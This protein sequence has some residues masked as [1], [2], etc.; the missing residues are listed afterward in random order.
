[1]LG[2]SL[3]NDLTSSVPCCGKP[4]PRLVFPV[5]VPFTTLVSYWFG[6]DPSQQ[7]GNGPVSCVVGAGITVGLKIFK[8]ML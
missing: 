2:S 8:L 3:M 6:E 1:M 4:L 5:S 7:S